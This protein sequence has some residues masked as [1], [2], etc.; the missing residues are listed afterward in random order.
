MQVIISKD[1]QA[2][3]IGQPIVATISGLN[4]DSSSDNLISTGQSTVAALRATLRERLAEPEVRGFRELFAKM[5][6]D[7]LEPAGERL[8]RTFIEKGFKSINSAVD[9]YNIVSLRW[10]SGIGMHDV[11][12]ESGDITVYRSHGGEEIIPLFKDKPKPIKHGDLVYAINGAPLAWLGQKD[13]DSNAYR[14]TDTSTEV[15]LVVL[16]NR[17]TSYDHNRSM[18]QECLELFKL[19]NPAAQISYI[20]IR[21]A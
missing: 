2:L 7:D 21:F 3:G 8:A 9:A 11:G 19:A 14:V 5:G 4:I 18:A 16:G 15:L 17:A 10:I 1:A 13:V 6:Y 20:P 12:G